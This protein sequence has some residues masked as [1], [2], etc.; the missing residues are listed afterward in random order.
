MLA[1]AAQIA[2]QPSA[3]S[4]AFVFRQ[5]AL[6]FLAA[7]FFCG[8]GMVWDDWVDRDIDANVARTK[9][10]PLVTGMVTTTEAMIWMV[11]QVAAS[12]LVLHIM[13]NGKDV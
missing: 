12:W 11:L 5:T 13:L 8:A 2:D 3:G 7:Y 6:C 9:N 1:G 4:L 10:R